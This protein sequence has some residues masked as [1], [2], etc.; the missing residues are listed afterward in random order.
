[1]TAVPRLVGGVTG[2]AVTTAVVPFGGV[3]ASAIADGVGAVKAAKVGG[4][5]NA[6]VGGG[7]GKAKGVKFEDETGSMSESL[8]G[9]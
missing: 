3:V 2:A 7:A 9:F 1:M 4:A 6:G 5:A 8:A